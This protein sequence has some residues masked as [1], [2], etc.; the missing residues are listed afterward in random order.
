MVVDPDKVH[1]VDL[2]KDKLVKNKL[3]LSIIG[4]SNLFTIER[5]IVKKRRRWKN[6]NLKM[7]RKMLRHRS[8]KK[9]KRKG[10]ILRGYIIKIRVT[11]EK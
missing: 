3:L 8:N 5:L 11:Q 10:K 2:N 4:I 9:D 6:N 1:L 7:R